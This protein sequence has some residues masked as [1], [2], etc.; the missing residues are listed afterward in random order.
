MDLPWDERV[1]PFHEHAQ[2]RDVR[3]ESARQVTQP[4]YTSAL[5]RWRKYERYLEPHMD[6]L[7]PFIDA[8]G[9][10]STST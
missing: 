9:Y 8:F 7:Q 2:S 6:T 1:A 5:A 4:L 3:T 10:S